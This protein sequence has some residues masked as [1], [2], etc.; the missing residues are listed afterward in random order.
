MTNCFR[1]HCAFRLEEF[2]PGSHLTTTTSMQD[3][4]ED[5]MAVEV[6]CR[7]DPDLALYLGADPRTG[8]TVRKFRVTPNSYDSNQMAA[9]LAGEGGCEAILG[10]GKLADECKKR[11]DLIATKLPHYRSI[12]VPPYQFDQLCD[13]Q[14]FAQ[15]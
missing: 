8:R 2:E 9:M 14:D 10:L 13:I 4:A 11:R 1:L 15:V 3:Q 7:N 12:R 5:V 6:N